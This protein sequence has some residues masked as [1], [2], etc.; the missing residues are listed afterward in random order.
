MTTPRRHRAL[1][2][3]AAAM[4]PLALLSSQAVGAEPAKRGFAPPR[5]SFILTR[6]LRRPLPDGKEVVTRRSYE[7]SILPDG[8][9]Y[10]VEGTLVGTEV[11]APPA[12]RAL[13]EIE[14]RRQDAGLFPM[15]LDAQGQIVAVDTVPD[16]TAAGQATETVGVWLAKAGLSGPDREVAQSFLNQLKGGLAGGRTLWPRDLFHPAAG[17]RSETSDFQLPDGDKGSVTVAT[18]A[19][20]RPDNGLLD[21]VERTVVTRMG[22]SERTTREIWQL[23]QVRGQR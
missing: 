21:R 10:R 17:E 8:T 13:A 18:A 15:Q 9:G 5:T 11:E 6:E 7:I 20:A 22:D 19:S 3:G 12:L 1:L 2:A 14:R 4:L 23:G 16:R